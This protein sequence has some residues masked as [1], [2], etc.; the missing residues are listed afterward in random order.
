MPLQG[1]ILEFLN[2]AKYRNLSPKTVKYYRESLTQ[3]TKF[4]TKKGITEPSEITSNAL[5]TYSAELL[6][7][8]TPGGAHALL[9]P[10]R[11]LMGFLV[12]EEILEKNPFQ[13]FQLPKL[14]HEKLPHITRDDYDTL[15][16]SARLSLNPLRD[17][18][19]ICLLFDC[20][21]RASE[22]TGLRFQDILK[23]KGMLKI[24]GKGAKERFVPVSRHVLKR[25]QT[26]FNSEREKS[27]LQ[28][29]FL[30]NEES[31]LTY[32]A[33]R[34]IV[35]RTFERVNIPAK[36]L[37]TF[38]R[39]FAVSWVK[40]GGDTFSLSKILGHTSL[41]MSLRYTT[42]DAEDLKEIHMRASPTRI[43]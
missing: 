18:A 5:R 26:Y 25:I 8:M 34:F 10:L 17:Q 37:H 14:P 22:L 40:N 9:R 31:S 15:M 36:S 33:L 43:Q 21:L 30:T 16:G 20:G 23:E 39:G 27:P 42:L 24:R 4:A 32:S 11:A 6:D 38:R 12:R 13:K 7:R 3:F 35:S 2:D 1:D 28:E 29:V 41:T 19:I